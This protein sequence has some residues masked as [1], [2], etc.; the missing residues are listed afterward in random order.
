[1]YTNVLNLVGRVGLA[2][3]FVSAGYGKISGYA[4]TAAY[5]ESMGVPGVLLPLVIALELGGG[6]A[7]MAGLFTKPMALALAAFSVAAAV[8]FHGN[9]GDP[10]QMIMFM[11]NIGLAGGL[12]LLAGNGPG[13]FSLDAKRA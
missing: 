1:M 3:I 6:L 5:M 13:E 10:M 8:L 7:I 12:L 4:G 9:V 2:L 11:K